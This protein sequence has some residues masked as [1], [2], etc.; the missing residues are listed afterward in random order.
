MIRVCYVDESGTG[1]MIDHPDSPVEPILVIS[2]IVFHQNHLTHL[3]QEFLTLKRTFFPGL[4]PSTVP[5]LQHV[6]AEIKGSQLRATI[7]KGG[8]NERRHTFGF[9]DGCLTLLEKY[10][11]KLFGRVWIKKVGEGTNSL[12]MYTYS[13]QSICNS[14]QNLLELENMDGIIIAD[15]RNPYQNVGVAH[16]IFTQKFKATGD[17]YGRILEMPVFGHSENHV[18]LQLADIICSALLYPMATFTYCTGHVNNVHVHPR[19]KLIKDRYAARVKPLQHRYLDQGR[20]RG[21]ITVSDQI[22]G[23]TGG[24]LFKP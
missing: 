4:T 14:L 11:S 7:R 1:G 24:E 13:I 22:S 5:F 16:S 20:Y 12:S 21:G 15:S 23:R 8:R 6:R 19:Y 18:G 2:G 3:T 9:I 10:N 17:A